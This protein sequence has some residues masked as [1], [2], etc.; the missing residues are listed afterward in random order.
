M[1][2]EHPSDA[3][4]VQCWALVTKLLKTVFEVTHGAQSFAAEAGGPA[5][6]PLQ[7]NGYFLYT[8]LEEL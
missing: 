3:S 4:K 1:G 5:M 8:T 6:D 2:G 7:T